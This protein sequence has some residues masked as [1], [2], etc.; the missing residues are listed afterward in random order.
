MAI[1]EIKVKVGYDDTALDKGVDGT[2]KKLSAFAGVA[3]RAAAGMAVAFTAASAA[4]VVALRSVTTEADR[5]A[6]TAQKIGIA[7]EELQRLNLAANR[8]GVTFESLRIGVSQLNRNLSNTAAGATS[9]A[10]RAFKALGI[11]VEN[12]DGSVK[13]AS[14]VI[15]EISEKF[16]GFKDGVNK[17]ALAMQIF[18]ES[19]GD[20]IPL[21]NQGSDA[22][23]KAKARSDAFG[24]TMSGGLTKASERLNDALA[25]LNT[26]GFGVLVQ[27]GE[28][29][30]PIMAAS[31]QS[32]A[33]W[34]AKSG[35]AHSAGA[36]LDTVLGNIEV[37]ALTTGSA[38]LFAFGPTLL[39]AVQTTT[40]AIGV[41][42]VGA[43]T[44][45]N[46][47]VLA[48]PIT[49]AFV[50]A[51]AAAF[52]FRDEIKKVFGVD[53]V[54]F[55][56]KASNFILN[57]FRAAYRDIKFVW[58]NLPDVL[59]A[60][61]VAAANSVIGELNRTIVETKKEI[62][63]LIRFANKVLPQNAQINPLNVRGGQL[64]GFA[65]TYARRLQ[66]PL[67]A[68]AKRIGEIMGDDLIGGFLSK[69]EKVNESVAAALKT[70]QRDAPTADATTGIDQNQGLKGQLASRLEVFRESF[71]N[72]RE[73]ANNHHIKNLD[74]L[75]QA[76]DQELLTRTQHDAFKAELE[77]KH[78]RTLQDIRDHGNHA[79]LS[80]TG[81]VLGQLGNL[82]QTHG[83]KNLKLVK[84]LSVAQALIA[85]YTGAAE[86]LKLPFPANLAASASVLAQGLGA[87]ASIK[88][89]SSSGGGGASG[90]RGG[91]VALPTSG[92]GGAAQTQQQTGEG[93]TENATV[94]VKGITPSSLLTGEMVTELMAQMLEKQRDGYKVVLA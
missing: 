55:A 78:Q 71:L 48:N 56:K 51:G 53:V 23:A 89:V 25:D 87:V 86:A 41:G 80:S 20:L 81:E 26:A 21:L 88:S 34:A 77:R 31:A 16:V 1:P 85:A 75:R 15:D 91:G 43:V 68:H 11:D 3:K 24:A 7:V 62:N 37:A 6:K 14:A 33:D 93:P 61:A 92:V 47:A 27:L 9:E 52:V 72:E 64:T 76:L 29:L 17:S 84:G 30:V 38:L 67:Q 94:F 4:T 65:N 32:L 12:A 46:A 19:G 63:L 10:S 82:I 59:G 70:P 69:A 22:L 49:A 8:S 50:A 35:L 79:M 58:R 42:L 36:A 44:A 83:K 66:R 45:V 2:K 60:A 90:G 18:G 5:M 13:T 54:A 74:T 28:R 57:S 40:T 73:L 39:T